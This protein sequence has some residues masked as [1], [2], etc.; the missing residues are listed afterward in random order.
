[1]R[2]TVCVDLDGVL[3]S[4]D[5]WK[6]VDHF[7]SPIPGAVEF[8]KALASFADVVIFT[9][10]CNPEVNDGEAVDSLVYRVR[11][12]LDMHGFVYSDV[13]AGTGKPLA[14]AYVDDRA[15]LFRPLKDVECQDYDRAFAACRALVSG[16]ELGAQG[17]AGS[18]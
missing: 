8:T 7:G 10:R 15:V 12:W 16:H 2:H 6:G 1:M 9:T 17:T 13:Y 5:G 11:N 18:L 3:A 14:A 4:Y